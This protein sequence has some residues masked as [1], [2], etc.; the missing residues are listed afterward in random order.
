MQA[1]R[2]GDSV[3]HG[4]I[5]DCDGVL[6]NTEA[7][8]IDLEIEAMARLGVTY[9]RETFVAKYMGAGEPDF[10]AGLNADHAAVHGT[11]LPAGFF[12]Q[13]KADKYAHL[14]RHIQAVPGAAA[15]AAG[16]SA[17]RA[18]ASSS[19][20]D[21]L[22][23]K[24]ARAGLAT[25][26]GGQVHSAEDVARAKPAPDLYLHAA[27]AL[28]VDPGLSLAIE[29][30][31]S[32]VMSA[33]AAGLTCWGFT[34]GGHCPPGHGATLRAAGA[35]AVFDTFEAIAAAYD[36]AGFASGGRA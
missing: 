18:V 26:F 7:L 36:A 21:A 4:V 16:L 27:Q 13:L 1:E 8:V 5:F 12:S 15:F 30:S 3:A 25:L 11:G 19:E 28:G 9:E 35:Q 34:G 29:D 20:R 14:D 32:G 24:L 33:R 6:V 17:L 31:A 23:M 10:E 22:S 2:K